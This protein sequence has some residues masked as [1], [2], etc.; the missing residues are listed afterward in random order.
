MSDEL[1]GRVNRALRDEIASMPLTVTERMVQERLTY[2]VGMPAVLALGLS[3]VLVAAVVGGA[4]VLGLPRPELG[5]DPSAMAS[6]SDATRD[7]HGLP[8]GTFVGRS[9]ID[10]TFCVAITVTDSSD[11]V[12]AAQWWT[13]GSSGQC[14][15]R[16][17]DVV[18]TTATFED[19]PVLRVP[20]PLREGGVRNLDLR[21]TG[22][23]ADEI[24]LHE[25]AFRRAAE[26]APTFAPV[27]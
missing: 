19:W 7:D 5:V 20:I 22:S 21:F 9:P 27:P 8:L 18:S 10:G 13:V 24:R 26:A 17:S 16:T 4:L 14:E 15:T 23:T 2:S 11:G 3:G 12:L 6:A 25:V 1:E